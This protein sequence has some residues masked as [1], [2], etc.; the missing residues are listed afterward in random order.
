MLSRNNNHCLNGGL[1][2]LIYKSGISSLNYNAEHQKAKD[3]SI[4]QNIN[5]KCSLRRKDLID[6]IFLLNK[7]GC[8]KNFNEK[9]KTTIEQVE[10]NFEMNR[11]E[12]KNAFRI[13]EEYIP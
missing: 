11:V 3:A 12:M 2:D 6:L 13:E 5:S 4:I 7:K 8:P 9:T 10:R 1:E